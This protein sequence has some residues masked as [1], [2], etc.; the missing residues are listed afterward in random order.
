[1]KHGVIQFRNFAHQ[2]Y[3]VQG[4]KVSL[5]AFDDKRYILEDGVETLAYGHRDIDSIAN[6][7]MNDCMV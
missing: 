2:I 7:V 5:S 6:P 3:T 4:K 1:M